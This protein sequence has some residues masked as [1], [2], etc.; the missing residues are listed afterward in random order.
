MYMSS[1][2]IVFLRMQVRPTPNS[3]SPSCFL[4]VEIKKLLIGMWYIPSIAVPIA[5]QASFVFLC[6]CSVESYRA[7]PATISLR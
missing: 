4:L 1:I 6:V 7:A 3:P 2:W 5:L